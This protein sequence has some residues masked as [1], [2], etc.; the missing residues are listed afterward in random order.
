MLFTLSLIAYEC[1]VNESLE[2]GS[3]FSL[4]KLNTKFEEIPYYKQ[5]ANMCRAVKCESNMKLANLQ[6]V[7]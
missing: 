1:N 3:K 5:S 2:L 6:C 7:L 4:S